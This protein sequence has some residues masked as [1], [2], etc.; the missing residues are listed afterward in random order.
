MGNLIAVTV[1]V[2]KGFKEKLL[3][4][5]MIGISKTEMG[6]FFFNGQDNSKI[7]L[8]EEVRLVMP[9]IDGTQKTFTLR[10]DLLSG[11]NLMIT[12]FTMLKGQ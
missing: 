2:P 5:F 1:E 11:V 12:K 4:F 7:G 9:N 8:H 10:V 6:N 3:T